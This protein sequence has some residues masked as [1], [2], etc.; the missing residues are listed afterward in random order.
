VR[1]DPAA[2]RKPTTEIDLIR[3]RGG[4]EMMMITELSGVL[5]VVLREHP[6]ANELIIEHFAFN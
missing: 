2:V 5:G 4:D 6:L 3:S 1:V